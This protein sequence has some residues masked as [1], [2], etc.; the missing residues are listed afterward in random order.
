LDFLVGIE[1]FQRVALTPA[2]FF[3]FS[4]IAPSEFQASGGT[5]AA[6]AYKHPTRLVKHFRL[7]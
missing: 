1:P 6:V 2:A 4:P 7:A 3:S 5:R